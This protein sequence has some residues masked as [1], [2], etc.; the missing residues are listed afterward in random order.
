T[1]HVPGLTVTVNGAAASRDVVTYNIRGQSY[2]SFTLFP[3]V[4]T[5]F[6]EVP[7]NQVL[8]GMFF[9][10]DQVQVLRGPQGVLFGRVTDGGNVM[11]GPKLPQNRFDASV[12]VKVGNYNLRTFDGMVNMPIVADHV[13]ARAAVE[14]GRRDGY[15]KNLFNDVDLDDVAYESYR[16]GL[17]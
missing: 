10:L 13:L 15:T 7:V 17:T 12:G 14:I 3:A 16:L 8:A 9:D 6:N 4:I 2:V 5:Y 11:L 1:Q